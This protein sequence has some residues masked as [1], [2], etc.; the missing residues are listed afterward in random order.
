M[1]GPILLQL[2]D[3][4]K[5]LTGCT[6][7]LIRRKQMVTFLSILVT[8]TYSTKLILVEKIAKP[9]LNLNLVSLLLC[10]Y[11]VGSL[12]IVL[13]PLIILML[14]KDLMK[15]MTDI[16]KRRTIYSDGSLV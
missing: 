2:L 8:A 4:T 15:T 16:Y 5:H 3:V 11:L 6:E 9:F 1:F 14:D 10:K 13:A 7:G 12:D